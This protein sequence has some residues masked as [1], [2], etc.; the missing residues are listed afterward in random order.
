MQNN[1]DLKKFLI[2]NKLTPSSQN[3][4][5]NEGSNEDKIAK[6]KEYTYT[7][8]GKKVIPDDIDFYGNILGIEIDGEVYRPGTP[9][10]KGNIELKP[11]KGKTGMYT[12]S[13]H[14]QLSE[15]KCDGKTVKNAT[16]NGDKSYN[17]EFEDGSKKKI[18]VSHDDWDA[19]NDAFGDKK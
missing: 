15:V 10:E 13:K 4:D 18:Y 17:V 9:D 16:Q 12:E 19:I 5:I 14:T 1:F 8:G 7:L 6:Y 2:E 11:R 3:E